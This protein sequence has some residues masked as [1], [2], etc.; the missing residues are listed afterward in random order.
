MFAFAV[1]TQS[2]KRLTLARDRLGIKP[3]YF[4]TAPWGIG[5]ASELKA[6]LTVGLSRRQLDWEALDS[7]SQ[8]GYIPAPATPLRLRRLGRQN[9]HRSSEQHRSSH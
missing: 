9:D 4:V 2:K 3:L 6:L 1:W 5:F 7:F 8:L